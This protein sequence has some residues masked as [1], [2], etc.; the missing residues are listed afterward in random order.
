MRIARNIIT[1]ALLLQ[2]AC[3]SATAPTDGVTAT[4]GRLAGGQYLID[5]VPAKYLVDLKRA[6]IDRT[7]DL[8]RVIEIHANSVTTLN[9]NIDT[10][11]R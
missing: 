7:S 4:G 8:P 11:I 9:V 1:L 10:G 3:H 6:G 2:L 5:L